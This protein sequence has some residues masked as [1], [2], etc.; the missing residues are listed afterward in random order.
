MTKTLVLL[1]AL[2]LPGAALA[3]AKAQDID[4]LLE[5]IRLEKRIEASNRVMRAAFLRGVRN[6]S[7]SNNPALA[8]LVEQEYDAAFPASRVIAEVRP[9][10]VELYDDK[11]SQEELRELTRMFKSPLYEKYRDVNSG[12]GRLILEATQRSVKSGMGDLMK[13][14]MDR[15]VAEGLVK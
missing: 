15:A 3:Q 10:V 1:A 7:K 2:L 9:R 4:T 12:V 13:K 6:R 14:V 5:V 8:R 11:F